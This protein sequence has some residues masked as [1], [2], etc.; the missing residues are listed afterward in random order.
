MTK[1]SFSWRRCDRARN[2]QLLNLNLTSSH[3]NEE[4]Q[5]HNYKL[6]YIWN[7]KDPCLAG[8]RCDQA[9]NIPPGRWI[10]FNLVLSTILFVNLLWHDVWKQEKWSSLEPRRANFYKVSIFTSKKVW[11]FLKKIQLTKSDSKRTRG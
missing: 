1:R 10:V 6:Y 4:K 5:A 9:I 8:S 2:I 11:T 3:D 7:E